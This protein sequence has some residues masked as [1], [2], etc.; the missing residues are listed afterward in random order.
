MVCSQLIKELQ[1]MIDLMGDHVVYI[2]KEC[3]I[4][5]VSYVSGEENSSSIW[6]KN[7]IIIS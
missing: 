4:D 3:S 1:D 2:D 5:K 7:R 6:V